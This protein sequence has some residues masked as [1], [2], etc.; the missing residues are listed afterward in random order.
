MLKW[1]GNHDQ[2]R[3]P[4]PLHE[5][6]KHEWVQLRIEEGTHKPTE[7][8]LCVFRSVFLRIS[9]RD[10]GIR[11]GLRVAEK[12][13]SSLHLSSTFLFNDRCQLIRTIGRLSPSSLSLIVAY[14]PADP[15][16]EKTISPARVSCAEEKMGL[17]PA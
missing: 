11:K 9:V 6:R 15:S 17:S 1:A 14:V 3:K 2:E 16:F 8:Q 5:R 12:H 13:P 7:K 4:R 10:L